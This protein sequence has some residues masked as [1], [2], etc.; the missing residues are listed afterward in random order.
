[1]NVN[2]LKDNLG[3]RKTYVWFKNIINERLLTA[4]KEK[5]Q[6]YVDGASLTKN[7]QNKKG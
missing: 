4:L 3:K 7:K 2:K 5:A 1:M 6:L